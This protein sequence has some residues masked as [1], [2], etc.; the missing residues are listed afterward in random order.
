VAERARICAAIDTF[1]YLRR[2]GRV[3]RLQAYAATMLDIKPVFAFA[4]GEAA[5]VGRP[6]T[7]RRAIAKVVEHTLHEIAGRPVHLAAIHAVAEDEARELLAA[8]SAREN[9]VESL[10]TAV[11]P[12]VG[13][14]TGPG[15]VGTAFFCD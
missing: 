12:V 4:G 13:A 3:N 14:H 8:V 6:R 7:R 2:S 10:V 15:L 9:V 1:E 11:T 5:P